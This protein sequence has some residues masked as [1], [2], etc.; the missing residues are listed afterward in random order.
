[1]PTGKPVVIGYS[2]FRLTKLPLPYLIPQIMKLFRSGSNLHSL[3]HKY[4]ELC[5]SVYFRAT[6]KQY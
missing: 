6:F 1:M 3:T 5:S 4:V 2:R